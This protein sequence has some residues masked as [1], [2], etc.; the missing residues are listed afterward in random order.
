M[1]WRPGGRRLVVFVLA[2]LVAAY[3][4]RVVVWRP[5]ALAGTAPQDGYTRVGGVV[6]VHT[7]LSDGGGTPQEVIGAARAASLGFVVITDHNNLDAKPSEG[8]H[9]G[10]LVVVGTEISTQSGHLVALGLRDPGYRFSGDGLDALHDVRDLGGVVFAAHPLSARPDFRFTGWDLPDGWGL[11]L[12]NGDSQWRAAGWARLVRTL[13]LYPLNPRY[14]LLSSLTTPQET[15]AHWD[16]LLAQRDVPGIAGADA[17]NRVLLSKRMAPRFP[18]YESVFSLMR[19]YAVLDTPLTGRADVD[20]RTVAQALGRGRSYIGLDAL[21]PADDISFVARAGGTQWTMGDTVPQAGAQLR[22]S[23]RM[24]KGARARILHDGR[25]LAAGEGEVQAVAAGE[26][27]YR[28]EVWLPGRSLPWVI[29]NPIYVFGPDRAAQRQTRAGWP[30]AEPPPATRVVLD[31]F[32]AGTVFDAVADTASTVEKP[33]VAAAEG[34]GGGAAARLRFH[35]GLPTPTHPDVYV[36][37]ENRTPR[38]LTGHTGLVFSIR[39]DGVYR[40]WLQVRDA[41]P[42]SKDEGTEWWFVSV[43][44]SPDWQRIHLPFSR[45][46]SINP[47]TDGRLDLSQVR[48]LAFIIDKGALPPGTQGTVWVDEIGAY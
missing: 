14:A 4:A 47:A 2:L 10:V 37:L 24:P 46:R 32:D 22:L 48:G 9:D 39:G 33:F 3:A 26:G 1:V 31:T 45:F 23:G 12:L 13:A 44:T 19:T 34:L 41:N 30:P 17:H 11:E 20:A 25:E 21:A 18:S 8:Y 35:L 43:R 29:T 42:K 7:T 27:V 36:A 6:H 28:A 38:D 16:S 40:L 15:L 5:A